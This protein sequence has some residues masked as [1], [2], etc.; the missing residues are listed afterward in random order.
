MVRLRPMTEAEFT[1][2][3][4]LSVEDYAQQRVAA[5]NSPLETQRE[6]A[7]RDFAELLPKGVRT[8]RQHLWCVEDETS[9]VVGYLWVEVNNDHR[10]F[11]YYIIMASAQRGRG[12]GRQT[13]ELLEAEL[14]PHGITHIALNVFSPNRRAAQLYEKVG[15]QVVSQ[16][17][18]K[19]LEPAATAPPPATEE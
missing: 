9:T 7:A 2:F 12:Y 3:R 10:A 17:M 13:L 18:A 4:D 1:A 5:F 19:A 16:T 15:Y 11:I 6:V 8:P 14:R